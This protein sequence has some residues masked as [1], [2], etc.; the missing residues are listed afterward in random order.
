M[1]KKQESYIYREQEY[2]E[3]IRLLKATI[4]DVS[5]KTL[6]LPQETPDETLELEDGQVLQLLRANAT[7]AAENEKRLNDGVYREPKSVKM[8]HTNIDKILQSINEM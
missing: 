3:T 8:I 5:K 2:R 4:D 7:E 6:L 1:F